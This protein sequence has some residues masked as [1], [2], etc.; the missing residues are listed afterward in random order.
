MK[1]TC[2]LLLDDFRFATLHPRCRLQ[3]TFG[4][5]REWKK[6]NDSGKD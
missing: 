2:Q 1:T 3:M 4:V 5:E 6:R